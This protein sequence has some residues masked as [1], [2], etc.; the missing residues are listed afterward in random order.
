MKIGAG[1]WGGPPLKT[2]RSRR[3]CHEKVKK[4]LHRSVTRVIS[5]VKTEGKCTIWNSSADPADP[6]DPGNPLQSTTIQRI[7]RIRCQQPLLGPSPT[8]AP[9]ARM[10]VVKT[11]SLKLCVCNVTAVLK[12]QYEVQRSHK[13]LKIFKFL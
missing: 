12:T 10:A 1:G 5:A 7:R 2:R 13:I 8:R 9:G 3:S 6:P 11:N 4:A